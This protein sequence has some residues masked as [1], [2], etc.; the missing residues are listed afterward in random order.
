MSFSSEGGEGAVHRWPTPTGNEKPVCN[1][2]ASVII[3]SDDGVCQGLLCHRSDLY[4]ELKR[5]AIAEGDGT[6]VKI[7]LGSK[8]VACDT[9]EGT[10]TLNSGEVIHADVVLGADGVNVRPLDFSQLGWTNWISSRSYVP[11]SSVPL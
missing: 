6:P 8:V 3:C 1:G 4:E 5:L 7:H 9:E 10:L 11:R 2:I